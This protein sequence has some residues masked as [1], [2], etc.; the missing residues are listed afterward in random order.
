MVN[1]MGL[2]N[3]S[4]LLRRMKLNYTSRWIILALDMFL[5]SLSFFIVVYMRQLMTGNYTL[6]PDIQ[7]K[8]ILILIAYL[9]NAWLFKTYTGV[10]RYS[11]IEDSFRLLLMVL[12]SSV[13]VM[14]INLAG[15][16]FTRVW[17]F[18]L[19]TL[20]LQGMIVFSFMFFVRLLVKVIYAKFLIIGSKK[21]NVIMLGAAVNSVVLAN[22]MKAE[23]EGKYLPVALL[24]LNGKKNKSINGMPIIPFDESRL[25]EI[26]E[27]HHTRTLIFLAT[28]M[29]LMKNGLAEKFLNAGIEILQLN[30]IEEFEGTDDSGKNISTYVHNI[31]IED[32]LGREPIKT[33]NPAIQQQLK[34]KVALIT[35][36]AGSIGSEIVRQLALFGADQIIMFDQAETPLNTLY[37]EMKEKFPD[38]TV[39]PYMGDIRNLN[40]LRQVFELYHPHFVYH[41]AAYKHVPM[42]ELHPVEAILDNVEGTKNVADFSLKYGVEKFVMI[43]TDKAVNPT[44]VMGASKRIA[45]I[46]VQSL[47]FKAQ[48]SRPDSLYTRFITTRFG[49]VL[50]SNGSVVPLFKEQIA[51][52]GPVTVTHKD[53]IRYF[54][55]IPEACNLVLE[56]GCMGKGGEIY[57]FDMGK[58]VR[59][60]DLAKKMISLS[61]LTLGKDIVITETGLRPGEK[62]YEE[63]LNDKETT[64]PTYHPKIMIGKVRQ[65]PYEEVINHIE[66]MLQ[67]ARKGNTLEVVAGMK[68]LVPEFISRNSVFESLDRQKVARPVSKMEQ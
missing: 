20:C 55:T 7:L 3:H 32:L 26:F 22:A 2:F 11:G 57:V 12:S 66:P 37:L 45:E 56:A 62:L 41:A 60:Y 23:V 43:S 33:D 48:A 67:H 40:R 58:P 29:N 25:V 34:N 19:V 5:V 17:L 65:Y 27:K 15:Y 6:E 38:A 47:F 51:K 46:Y 14:L 44:N 39:I 21:K 54:M 50:G 8:F 16:I 30:Q 10:V 18:S 53:I 68:Q 59:I 42:M 36:A 64:L 9:F 61:G 49:N 31:Q 13:T 24:D 52:G 35:G 1:W 28:Q 4:K 63:L